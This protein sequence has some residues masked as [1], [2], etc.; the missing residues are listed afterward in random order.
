MQT[1]QTLFGSDPEMAA[2]GHVT[3]IGSC[4]DRRERSSRPAGRHL[5]E[6]P[7][8]PPCHSTLSLPPQTVRQCSSIFTCI[9]DSRKC[10]TQR[11]LLGPER[12]PKRHERCSC[13]CCCSC[14][15]QIFENSLRLLLLGG[16]VVMALDLW[17]RDSRFDSRPVHCRVA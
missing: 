10:T 17:S 4:C 7:L 8:P 9:Y 5:S 12:V 11:L 15:Y 1:R 16:V 2:A 6:Q 3:R 13:S 14:C